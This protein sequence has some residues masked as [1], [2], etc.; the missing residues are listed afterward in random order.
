ME[1]DQ[2]AKFAIHEAAREGKSTY[3]GNYSSISLISNLFSYKSAS[4]VESLLNVSTTE[5][6]PHSLTG[7]AQFSYGPGTEGD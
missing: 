3:V 6:K 1:Q 7:R 4:V 5:R 2:S